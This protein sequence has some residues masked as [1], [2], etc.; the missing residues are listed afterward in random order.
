MLGSIIPGDYSKNLRRKLTDGKTLDNALAELRAEG[1][2]I[3]ECIGAV[4]K[5][6][7]C[8]LSEAKRIV[9]LSPAWSDVS[10]PIN[11]ELENLAKETPPSSKSDH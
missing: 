11:R 7:G 1:V 8:D 9:N 10:E 3:V 4:K 2:S 6:R 5:F